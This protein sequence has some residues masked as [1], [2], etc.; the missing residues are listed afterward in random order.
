MRILIAD[1]EVVSRRL[2]ETT[3]RKWGHE[4]VAVD[5]GGEAWDL[6]DH[7]DAPRL[8]ILDWT[9][10]VIDGLGLCRNIRARRGAEYTYVILLTA[11]GQKQDIVR[12]LNAGADDYITKP[13]DPEELR[14]RLSAAV[15]ILDL[16]A[17]LIAAREALQQQAT[18]D[19]LTG[20]LN[21]SAILDF[22]QHAI[23]HSNREG[24]SVGVIMADLDMFKDIND[25]FG[26]KAGDTA[27][28]E[29]AQR[30]TETL[31]DYDA[32]GRYGGEEF[33][34]VLPGCDVASTV[35]LAER[36]RRQ[37]AARPLAIPECAVSL[38]LSLGA[39]ASED[40]PMADMD[41]LVNAADAA[42]YNAKRAGRNRVAVGSAESVAG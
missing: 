15:R 36:L 20:L 6:L 26:H 42:L 41:A 9:M 10:P 32:V 14:M 11:R 35:E 18:H 21:R 7:D 12:G 28:C 4:V 8:A 2:L 37:I 40:S 33:L 17:E 13:F 34:I 29:V 16:Q 3:L 1:D 30:M 22:L 25:R 39:V 5:D 38:S 31:R 23:S 24:T 19:Y 27:L